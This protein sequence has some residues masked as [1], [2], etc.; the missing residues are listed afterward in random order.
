MII[1]HARLGSRSRARPDLERVSLTL[2]RSRCQVSPAPGTTT[3]TGPAAGERRRSHPGCEAEEN[4]RNAETQ[5]QNHH[6]RSAIQRPRRNKEQ[7]LV[8]KK[9]KVAPLVPKLA[10]TRTK[11]SLSSLDSSPSKTRQSDRIRS[12]R[13]LRPYPLRPPTQPP[14]R[15]QPVRSPQDQTQRQR[16]FVQPQ[17]QCS[18]HRLTMTTDQHIPATPVAADALPKADAAAAAAAAASGAGPAV[19]VEANGT[20]TVADVAQLEGDVA[21]LALGQPPQPQGELHRACAEGRV[22]GVRAVLAR[23]L[24]QLE[25]LGEFVF[26]LG[27]SDGVDG[28]LELDGPLVHASEELGM[29]QQVPANP[30]RLDWMHSDRARRVPRP[31]G[32]RARAADGRRSGPSPRADHGPRD[33]CHPVPAANVRCPPT[34]CADGPSPVLPARIFPGRPCSVCASQQGPSA[35][36]KR[37]GR[38]GQPAPRRGR[39]DDPLP[40]LSQLQVRLGVH[41]LPPS[42][43]PRS[44]RLLPGLHPVR[45][46]VHA[47]PSKRRVLPRRAGVCPRRDGR[48][49]VARRCRCWRRSS[50]RLVRLDPS[51]ATGAVWHA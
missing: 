41:V 30:R 1:H 14:P 34:V 13:R 47:V 31:C 17:Y 24:D 10:I 26:S 49:G 11:S 28:G 50:A 19:A 3:S 46:R 25:T 21:N 51:R 29:I 20:D 32:R 18:S 37:L 15:H 35:E 42:G 45:G 39:K 48:G 12:S 8:W 9:N 44:R 40:Q 2:A 43:C 16:Q 23:G 36:W 5:N 6:A 7:S 27:F 22:D 4:R 38:D 33:A